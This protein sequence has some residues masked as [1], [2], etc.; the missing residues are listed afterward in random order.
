MKNNS[1]TLLKAAAVVLLMYGFLS[2]CASTH[3]GCA[4]V[5][6][7]KG[8]SAGKYYGIAKNSKNWKR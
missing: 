5:C 1:L 6:S 8:K 7:N 2:S 4:G 3:S